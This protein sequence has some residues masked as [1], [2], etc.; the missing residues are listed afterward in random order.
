MLMMPPPPV[1]WIAAI[2]CLMA[3]RTLARFTS[4]VT[5][6]LFSDM[7][8]FWL[9]WHVQNGVGIA[10]EAFWLYRSQLRRGLNWITLMRIAN[11]GPAMPKTL[12]RLD[13]MQLFVRIVDSGSISA[14]GRL[15]GLSQPAASRQLR[16]LEDMV[17]VRLLMR[18]THQLSLTEDGRMFLEDA[19]RMLTDWQRSAEALKG[20]QGELSG[21]LKLA[22]PSAL[23]QSLFADIACD[24]LRLHPRVRLDW[25]VCD[26]P[27][28]LSTGGFDLWIRVGPVRNDSLVIRT[29]GSIERLVVS[30]PG[31]VGLDDP[32]T[33][34]T[35]LDRFP[36]VLLSSYDGR[37]FA[38]TGPGEEI[39][40]VKPVAAFETDNLFAALQAT[41]HGIGYSL[42][43]RWLIAE[44][45]QQGRLIVQCPRWQ[46]D[47]LKLSIALPQGRFR[48]KRVNAF[49]EFLRSA[50]PESS[51]GIYLT[52]E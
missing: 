10:V 32:L 35:E 26:D 24:F 17:G 40:K 5:G 6:L 42:L 8:C 49:V 43:P 19:R 18:T 31:L 1:A 34:P 21:G 15:M 4:N 27:C 13:L 38:L 52:H 14:A 36:A 28:D 11:E 22:V 7:E 25:R 9:G 16:M 23:G 12:D 50:I 37:E 29:L 33:V 41:I 51:L 48:P 46:P 44:H 2:S 45:L 39:R 3:N 30:V 47:S 20:E